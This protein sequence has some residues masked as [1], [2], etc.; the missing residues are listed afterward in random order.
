MSPTRHW[1]Q[2]PC[3]SHFVLTHELRQAWSRLSFDVRQKEMKSHFTGF[4]TTVVGGMMLSAI[5][6]LV[7]F[8]QT[9]SSFSYAPPPVFLFPTLSLFVS[10]IAY[11][12]SLLAIS[13]FTKKEDKA[14]SSTV[15]S[16]IVTLTAAI[17][18]VVV[19]KLHWKANGVTV[20]DP[21]EMKTTEPNKALEPTRVIVTDPAAQAPRQSPVRLI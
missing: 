7:A 11:L 10:P 9:T 14:T 12:L 8:P 21:K 15:L 19:L 6:A 3:L 5:I 18:F 17:V 1:S 2:R 16:L 13:I 20:F 4:L